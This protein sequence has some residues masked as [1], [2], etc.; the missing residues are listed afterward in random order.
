[1]ISHIRKLGKL[2]K[3]GDAL[4]E[5]RLVKHGLIEKR[6]LSDEEV[7]SIIIASVFLLDFFSLSSFPPLL[8]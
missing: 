4:S 5:E 6:S 7:K 1:M 2:D 3:R 8:F